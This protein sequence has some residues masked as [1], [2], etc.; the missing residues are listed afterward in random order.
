MSA[1][2]DDIL[3]LLVAGL[4]NPSKGR[5]YIDRDTVACTIT[6]D[7]GTQPEQFPTLFRAA[8]EKELTSM[9][10][11]PELPAKV[12]SQRVSCLSPNGQKLLG[13]CH[14][15]DEAPFPRQLLEKFA[16]NA[17]INIPDVEA[18]LNE[19]I[20]SHMIRKNADSSLSLVPNYTHQ[21]AAHHIQQSDGFHQY[22]IAMTAVFDD[23]THDK[24]SLGPDQQSSLLR[25]LS[26]IKKL[27]ADLPL[28][29]TQMTN[30]MAMIILIHTI[31]SWATLA[32]AHDYFI[33]AKTLFEFATLLAKA[34]EYE[35]FL[36]KTVLEKI[37]TGLEQAKKG[38]LGSQKTLALTVL[39]E[40]PDPSCAASSDQGSRLSM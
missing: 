31:P 12:L 13:F 20:K 34:P 24:G 38:S 4:N 1:S 39:S 8:L 18:T 7:C 21:L 3:N 16:K 27:S 19:L 9:Q 30:R 28:C 23:I 36:S 17:H 32:L 15:V 26:F 5:V 11:P 29:R 2:Y 6:I 35:Y 22:I 37:Q 25:A 10:A 40:T 14:F 33:D